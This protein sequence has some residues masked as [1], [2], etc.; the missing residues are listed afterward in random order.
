VNAANRTWEVQLDTGE[1]RLEPE[2]LQALVRISTQ[3]ET[4]VSVLVKLALEEFIGSIDDDF[5]AHG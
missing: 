3:R 4:T 5:P 1:L 2:I